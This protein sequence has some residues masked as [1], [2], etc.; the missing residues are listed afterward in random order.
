MDFVFWGLFN[1]LTKLADDSEDKIAK[2]LRT[3]QL[4]HEGIK[5][6]HIIVYFIIYYYKIFTS[7]L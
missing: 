2:I 4:C 6:R 1:N 3:D 5:Y 7:L